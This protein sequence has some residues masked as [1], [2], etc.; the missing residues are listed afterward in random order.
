MALDWFI[1]YDP[2]TGDELKLPKSVDLNHYIQKGF[3][4]K[5]PKIEKPK[6]KT[7]SESIAEVKE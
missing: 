1:L 3:L 4:G 7:L 5:K 6:K 2:N